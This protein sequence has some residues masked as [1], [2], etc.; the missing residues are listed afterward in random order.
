MKNILIIL[1]LLPIYTFSQDN[2][3]NEIDTDS[4]WANYADATFKGLKIVNFEST[5]LVAKNQ[6]TFIVAHRFGSIENGFDTFFGL[7]DAVTRLNFIY[8]ISDGFNVGVSRSSYQ[9][10]YEFSTKYRILRQIENGSPFTVV[11]FNELLINTALNKDNLPLLEFKH[12]LT[13]V[14]QLLVSRKINTNLSLELAPTFFHEN[15]VAIDEQD[16]SQYA[17]GIGGRYKLGKRWSINLDY[18]CHLNRADN[19]PYKNPLSIGFDLETGGHVFQMHFT[20]AQGMNTNTYLGQ[21]TGD[22]GDGDIF[23]GFNLSRTF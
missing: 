4:T 7:D 10:I 11:G 20:N 8:G 23:F 22:W 5:K 1:F 3:L 18:G 21:A 14:A 16:N 19:S 6:F 17:L 15:Y 9:K 13:Y 2:L 12:R